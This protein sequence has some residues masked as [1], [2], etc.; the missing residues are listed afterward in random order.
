[1]RTHIWPLIEDY[2]TDYPGEADSLAALVD[3]MRTHRRVQDQTRR[4]NMAGHLTVSGL[5]VAPDRERVLL[6]EHRTLGKRLQPGGHVEAGD[7]SPLAAAYREIEE[8]TGLRAAELNLLAQPRSALMP[9]DI[10]SH[11][12]PASIAKGEAEHIQHDLRYLFLLQGEPA[13]LHRSPEDNSQLTWATFD[14]A[15]RDVS[16]R[17][18]PDKLRQLLGGIT[19]G[20]GP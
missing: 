11:V 3:F 14:E 20:P 9:V 6:I 17:H 7:E 2:I 4:T 18:L 13:A 5:I 19:R 10:N 1:M 8:E 12:I 16:Q 15:F